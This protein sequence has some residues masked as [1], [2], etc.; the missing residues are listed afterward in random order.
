LDYSLNEGS[1]STIGTGT[2]PSATRTVFNDY[3]LF[4]LPTSWVIDAFGVGSTDLDTLQ[5]DIEIRYTGI[6]DTTVVTDP[7]G[8][9]D[10]LITVVSGGQMAS[11]FGTVQGAANVRNHPFNPSPGTNAAFLLRIPIEVWNKD[12]NR[13]L[14]IAFRDRAQTLPT[15]TTS[16]KFFSWN[17]NARNY[18][19]VI[20]SDYDE[21]KIVPVTQ[22][23]AD[24][25]N[26]FATWVVVW[27]STRLVVGDVVTISYANP[28]QIGLDTY[29]F[30]TTAS[31]YSSDL[32]SDDVNKI[33][34]FPN[35][36]YGVNPQEI[37]KYERFV[38]INHLP[39]FATIRVFNLAGQLVRTIEKTDPGQFQRWD[40]L[41]DSGLPVASGLYI[42]YVDM[43]ELGRTKILK[44][45][46]IQEQQILDRY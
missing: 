8:N 2:A 45:A 29:R 36:Y 33:N 19:C 27:Y 6:L 18:M 11:V 21:T 1:T 44:A 42:I 34:V 3:T 17:P 37:N 25:E 43:P 35:P 16:D 14:N 38:T 12:E 41:T 13:Q 15:D 46:I 24:P 30:E 32:A 9:I 23:P 10:T 5:Q 31:A 26:A 7:G 22:A 4:G 40:L 39:D 20:N 28:F